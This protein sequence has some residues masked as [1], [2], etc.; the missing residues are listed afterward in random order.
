MRP[1]HALP[2]KS[3]LTNPVAIR[4]TAAYLPHV[5]WPAQCGAVIPCLN[6]AD[7]IGELVAEV[8]QW[9]PHVVVI[10][11]GSTDDT[12]ARAQAA[13]AE[14][15]RH[16]APQGKGAALVDGW[17]HTRGLGLAWA[18]CLDGD[19]QHAPA[20]IPQFLSA[21]EHTSAPL[22]V[23]NRMGQAAA[24]PWLRR[25]VN[26]WMSRRL[27]T[28][29]GREL[30]DSQCGFR[31]LRIDAWSQLPLETRHFEIESELLVAFA[32]AGLPI[33]FVPV[34]VIY[35]RERSKIHP[36]RDTLRWFR[37]W[38]R[39]RSS[40]ARNRGALRPGAVLQMVNRGRGRRFASQQKD[41]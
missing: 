25:K 2:H 36:W 28:L 10:D 26:R 15:I 23:G 37:W 7:T 22:I 16:A 21:A 18:I 31:L 11:D 27:S 6:E 39:T 3:C 41:A 1:T 33:E 4:G 20:D 9:L 24:M 19:G 12:A 35:G 34:Q 29:T 32:R 17:N 8:R 38:R 40:L 14:V 5:N 13:G 30:P